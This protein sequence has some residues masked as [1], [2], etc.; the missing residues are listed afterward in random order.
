[1]VVVMTTMMRTT[2]EMMMPFFPA[3]LTPQLA[4]GPARGPA[5]SQHAAATAAVGDHAWSAHRSFGRCSGMLHAEFHPLMKPMCSW[6][7]SVS[8][9]SGA[10]IK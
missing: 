2:M 6:W 8:P 9:R 1:M 7:A 10:P 4:R 5:R 3:D